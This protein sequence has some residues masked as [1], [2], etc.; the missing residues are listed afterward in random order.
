M[1]VPQSDSVLIVTGGSRGIGA[2]TVRLAATRGYAVCVNYLR[3]RQA[4]DEL[5]GAVQLTG[6][7]A[8]AVQADVGIEEDVV[9]LFNHAARELGRPTALVNNA[10]TL[11]GQMRL[12]EMDAA[13][14]H[15]TFAVNA[16]GPMLCAR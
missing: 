2:A 1:P 8:V 3:N 7:R 9:R 15:R 16:I 10:A 14:L 12:E 4:A 5:V 6:G 13:R 11:E